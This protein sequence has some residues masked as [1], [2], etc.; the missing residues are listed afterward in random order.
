[1]GNGGKDGDYSGG[2]DMKKGIAERTMVAPTNALFHL[3]HI[4]CCSLTT[5]TSLIIGFYPIHPKDEVL[6]QKVSQRASLTSHPQA[7]TSRPNSPRHRYDALHHWVH[8]RR[9]G[10]GWEN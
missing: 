10:R 7:R 1:M 6:K 2:L 4:A 5:R 9:Y 3:W 8:H